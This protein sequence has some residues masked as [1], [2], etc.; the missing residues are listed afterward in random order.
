MMLVCYSSSH[1]DHVSQNETVL[2]T[3]EQLNMPENLL[4]SMIVVGN[5]IDLVSI[6][7]HPNT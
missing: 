4:E 1:P 5:K 2:E 6:P 3:L 7:F